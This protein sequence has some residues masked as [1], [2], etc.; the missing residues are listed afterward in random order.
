MPH[1]AKQIGNGQFTEETQRTQHLWYR[2]TI[3]IP[4]CWGK[5]DIFWM[6]GLGIKQTQQ[7]H[8]CTWWDKHQKYYTVYTTWYDSTMLQKHEVKNMHTCILHH[9]LSYIRIQ[10]TRLLI[11]PWRLTWNIVVEVWKI[12]FLSKWVICRFHVN[13]AGCNHFIFPSI[14]CLPRR[15]SLVIS[16]RSTA[17]AAPC[18]RKQPLMNS[19]RYR[20]HWNAPKTSR[21][22]VKFLRIC[23]VQLHLVLFGANFV[24]VQNISRCFGS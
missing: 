5:F 9:C 16:K 21:N 24:G 19:W 13:L 15:V 1:H 20:C 23:F 14:Q 17:R 10:A 8:I 11:H 2:S 6:K 18:R 7:I 3:E 22:S 12:I 4:S